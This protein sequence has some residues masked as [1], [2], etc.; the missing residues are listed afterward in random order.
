[1]TSNFLKRLRSGKF[2]LGVLN[3]SS[4]RAE[5][6]VQTAKQDIVGV[7]LRFYCELLNGNVKQLLGTW[8]YPRHG[9]YTNEKH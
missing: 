8:I 7:G 9:I 4:K 6:D 2:R 3:N 1:M 5:T